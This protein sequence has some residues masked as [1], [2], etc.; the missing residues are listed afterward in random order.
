MKILNVI[1]SIDPMNGGGTAERTIQ[2]CKYLIKS[3]VECSIITMDLGVAPE[4]LKELAGVNIITLHCISKRFYF[5]KLS[6]SMLKKIKELVKSADLIHIMNHWTVINAL[7]Y[8]AAY[9]LNKPY[10]VCPAGALLKFGRSKFLKTCYNWF[11]GNN[12]IRHAS[13]CI[14]VTADEVPHFQSYGINRSKIIIIPNGINPGDYKND[15]IITFREKFNL[16]DNP[17]ILFLGRLNFIKGPD[18]LL[19]AFCNVK[20]KLKNYHLVIAGPDEGQLALLKKIAAAYEVENRVHF[21]GYIRGNDKSQAYHAADLLVIPSRKEAM[22]IVV[23]EAGIAG[24]PVLITS[25]CGLNEIETISGGK[26][27]E[28]SIDGLQEG[29]VEMLTGTKTLKAIGANLNKFVRDRYLWDV[30][31][32][33]YIMLYNQILINT[34]QV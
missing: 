10:V 1:M 7:I 9:R 19:Q 5:P 21:I 8:Y 2:M 29:L 24:T 17:I 18:M 33:K 26:V 25:Q 15:D 28:A 16:R 3:G 6:F 4:S 31:I 14:A 23:L 20:D 11:V 22:S 32:N 27:V 30:I 13:F 12:I 34:S